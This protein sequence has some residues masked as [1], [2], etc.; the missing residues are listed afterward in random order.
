MREM[1]EMNLVSILSIAEIRMRKVLTFRIESVI[2]L[3]SFTGLI[4]E[5]PK[6]E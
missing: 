1:A 3:I 6:K 5:L 4:S 2:V